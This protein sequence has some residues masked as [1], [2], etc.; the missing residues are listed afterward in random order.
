[1][2][3]EEEYHGSEEQKKKEKKCDYDTAQGTKNRDCRGRR[4][5][6]KPRGRIRNTNYEEG[7]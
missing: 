6:G 5:R 3:T 1:M 7:K 2:K 4:E